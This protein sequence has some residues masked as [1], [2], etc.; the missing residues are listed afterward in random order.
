MQQ[1]LESFLAEHKLSL[2]KKISKGYVSEVFLV[3]NSRGKKFALKIEK[4]KSPRKN[5]A[6]KEAKNLALANLAGIGPRLE[7][8]DAKTRTVLMEF[9]DGPTFAHW[10][11]E[12]NPSKKALEKFIG[13][14][15]L[16]AQKLDEIRLSHGQIAGLGKNILVRKNLPVIIDFEKASIVRRCR[17]KNQVESLLFRNPHSDIAK[18]VNGVLKNGY[19]F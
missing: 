10:L 13:A 1:R 4:E 2:V 14:L 11:F 3:K 18:K 19:T 15:L 16:Q 7:S 12:K 9:V 6:E 17:N 8:F 5:M